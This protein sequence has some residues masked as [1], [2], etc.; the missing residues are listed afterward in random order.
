MA[1]RIQSLIMLCCFVAA[2]LL[3]QGCPGQ[4]DNKIAPKQTDA[5]AGAISTPRRVM[6]PSTGSR[7]DTVIQLPSKE[8]L[9]VIFIVLSPEIDIVITGPGGRRTGKDNV[10]GTILS[11]IPYS[12][13]SSEYIEDPQGEGGMESKQLYIRMPDDGEYRISAFS[14]EQG[15]YNLSVALHD[16]KANHSKWD[17][18]KVPAFIDSTHDYNIVF[19]KNNI[20]D[21]RVVD[22]LKTE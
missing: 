5:G 22:G 21:C 1:G 12:D 19:R 4:P 18:V 17:F 2:M 20:K 3:L 13:Y 15:N 9:S 10:T 11:E 7:G 16:S 14:A 8:D 6:I